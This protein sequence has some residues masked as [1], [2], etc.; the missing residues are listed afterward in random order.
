[1]ID[2]IVVPFD[3]TEV[4][5]R[6]LLVAP[7]LARRAGAT[8]ELLMVGL[9]LSDEDEARLTAFA[10]RAGCG[11]DYL[12]TGGDPEEVLLAAMRHGGGE[13]WCMG[14]HARRGLGELIAGSLSERLVRDAHRPLVLVG[15]HV[16]A[17]P[18]GSVLAVA[19]DG[20][21][22]SAATVQD[23]AEVAGALGMSLQL[24]QVASSGSADLPADAMETAYVRRVAGQTSTLVR[25]EVDYDVL[26]G[27]SPAHDLATYAELHR[28]I[29]MI[30]TATHG[31]SARQRLVH[32]STSFDLVRHAT[33]PVLVVHPA[34][35]T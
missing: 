17:P 19:V 16:S 13:L 34:T 30:A 11:W 6:A 20:T 31:R 8:V 27:S 33:V 1:M 23:M 22:E 9:G 5:E 15:P 18:D 29:A 28:D 21:K 35:W 14:S 26:H 3:A 2:R 32:P 7:E 12:N 24:L 10:A 4:A 25:H